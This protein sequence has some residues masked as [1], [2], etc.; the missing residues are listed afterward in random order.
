MA[1]LNGYSNQHIPRSR[2]GSGQ[3]I[4]ADQLL[5]GFTYNAER[6]RTQAN[7]EPD[8][9]TQQMKIFRDRMSVMD[10][11]QRTYTDKSSSENP[12]ENSNMSNA[13]GKAKKTHQ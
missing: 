9:Y 6:E 3:D 7:N 12:A 1:Q 5:K 2:T 4:T 10:S 8:N 13:I 11:T